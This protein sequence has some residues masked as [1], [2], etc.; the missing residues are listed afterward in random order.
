MNRH[1]VLGIVAVV[2]ALGACIALG[3]WSTVDVVPHSMLGW[4]LLIGLGVPAVVL[5]EAVGDAGSGAR[6]LARLSS[7]M[8]VL[9][10][11]PLVLAFCGIA[12]LL[13]RIVRQVVLAA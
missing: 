8:R 4:A 5:V 6:F 2:V 7:P 12:G 9:V 13:F 3:L 10:A 1:R 11:I